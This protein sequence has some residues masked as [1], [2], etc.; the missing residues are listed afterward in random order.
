MTQEIY[1]LASTRTLSFAVSFLNEFLPDRVAF[2]N[3][4]PIPEL[5]DAPTQVLSSDYDVLDFLEKHPTE[6]YGLY[7]NACTPES[8]VRQAMLFYT[9]DANLILGLA[10]T[11]NR[12]SQLWSKLLD[13]SGTNVGLVGWEQRPPD[14]VDEFRNLATQANG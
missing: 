6:S 2:A 4:Y 7:W 5:S 14:T 9:V 12:Q 11:A 8:P 10:V 1:A 13:F 3:E